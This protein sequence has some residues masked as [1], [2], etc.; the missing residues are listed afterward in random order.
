MELIKSLNI[1][2][3]M[4]KSQE[5]CLN[6]LISYIRKIG[7]PISRKLISY[8]YDEGEVYVFCG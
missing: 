1:E 8:Y 6:D 5:L 3:F 2:A 7:Y 4:L